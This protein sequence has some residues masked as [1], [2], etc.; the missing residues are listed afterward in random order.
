MMVII[1]MCFILLLHTLINVSPF[2][3]IS[4]EDLILHLSLV[5]V[6]TKRVIHNLIFQQQ[7]CIL[8]LLIKFYNTSQKGKE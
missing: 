4:Y 8:S 7:G 1:D 2:I 3:V 6:C 5:K